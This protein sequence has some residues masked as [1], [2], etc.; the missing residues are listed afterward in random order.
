MKTQVFRKELLIEIVDI[1]A[2][3]CLRDDGLDLPLFFRKRDEEMKIDSR[4]SGIYGGRIGVAYALM[5]GSIAGGITDYD[6]I[7]YNQLKLGLRDVLEM[8][9]SSYYTGKVGCL[10]Y[11]EEIAN[12]LGKYKE[13]ET[14]LDS[15][16]K[17]AAE[18]AK[19][20]NCGFDLL[21]G[22]SGACLGL[23]IGLRRQRVDCEVRNKRLASRLSSAALR[24][25]DGVAWCSA[26]A[27]NFP[28][29]GY[30]HGAAGI[31]AV[32]N[33]VGRHLCDEGL[34]RLAKKG[35]LYEEQECRRWGYIPDY[36]DY[37]SDVRAQAGRVY[38][39]PPKPPPRMD[40]WCNGSHGTYLGVLSL[41]AAGGPDWSPYLDFAAKNC[42]H[43]YRYIKYSA[44]SLSLCHG[45]A[46]YLSV[47]KILA[48]HRITAVWG[49]VEKL[50][51]EILARVRDVDFLRSV[52][53]GQQ[54]LSLFLGL[55]GVIISLLPYWENDEYFNVLIPTLEKS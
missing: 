22:T 6:S 33:V 50:E 23:L 53:R 19:S 27:V 48:L 55:S 18:L 52:G 29:C 1:V 47:A 15:E 43:S 30:S 24:I 45:L 40:A 46:G 2:R 14:V 12:Y 3:S 42:I 9:F 4:Y 38:C 32:L 10:V 31:A 16:W 11:A 26:V 13:I 44:S 8:K 5:M 34:Q 54:D 36:R 41:A 39:R 7:I 49:I 28:L 37:R 51:E 20:E 25:G 35:I 21:S 17:H